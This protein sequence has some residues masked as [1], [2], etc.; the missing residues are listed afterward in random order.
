ME[1]EIL[2]KLD[3]AF[4]IDLLDKTRFSTDEHNRDD[5]IQL[6]IKHK[7]IYWEYKDVKVVEGEKKYKKWVVVFKKDK[8]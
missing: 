1:Q 5:L 8:K 3:I 6:L 7:Y 2:K 4:N